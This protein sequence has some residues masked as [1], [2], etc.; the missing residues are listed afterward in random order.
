MALR[1]LCSLNF[2]GLPSLFDEVLQY[3]RSANFPFRIFLFGSLSGCPALSL[4]QRRAEILT[5]LLVPLPAGAA[6]RN[7]GL[8][9]YLQVWQQCSMQR[10]RRCSGI[11]AWLS[12]GFSWDPKTDLMFLDR[13]SSKPPKHTQALGHGHTSPVKIVKEVR[14]VALW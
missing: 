14:C 7:G 6:V 9:S 3:Y 10:L 1:S 8:L 12:W 13:L 2:L 11:L 5:N 4:P